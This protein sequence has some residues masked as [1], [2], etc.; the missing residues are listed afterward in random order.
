MTGPLEN[1][2]TVMTVLCIDVLDDLGDFKEQDDTLDADVGAD[3]TDVA[4]GTFHSRDVA[5]SY[6]G[7]TTWPRI[8]ACDKDR[9]GERGEWIEVSSWWDDAVYDFD[10]MDVCSV[11]SDWCV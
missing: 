1:Y 2:S 3:G 8:D 6:F 10:S 4:D 11:S 7:W 5:F 9:R